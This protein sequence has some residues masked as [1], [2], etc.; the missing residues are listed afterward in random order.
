MVETE[1]HNTTRR[2]GG[3]NHPRM[4][5]SLLGNL[6]KNIEYCQR[7]RSVDRDADLV[8]VVDLNP[9]LAQETAWAATWL[10]KAGVERCKN[11]L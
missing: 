6:D 11:L 4:T 8:A 5:G 9:G 10:I 1:A 3:S 2:P 7:V